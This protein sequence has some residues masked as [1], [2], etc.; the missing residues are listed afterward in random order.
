MMPG[1]SSV[2]LKIKDDNV[3]ALTMLIKMRP[4]G[5][6]MAIIARELA[7]RLAVLSFP[8]DAIHTPGIAHVAAD[9]LSRVYAPDGPG[10]VSPSLH[11][12]LSG[13]VEA[14]AAP[15]GDAWYTADIHDSADASAE[16][17]SEWEPWYGHDDY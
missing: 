17:E 14:I 10:H 3:T 1:P 6:K 8:P 7:L 2:V 13:A 11:H 4:K 12:S 9:A 5:P 16:G 15:R